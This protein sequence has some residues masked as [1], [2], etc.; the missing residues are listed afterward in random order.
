MKRFFQLISCVA[1]VALSTSSFAQTDETKKDKA[2]ELVAKI[3]RTCELTPEQSG[4]LKSLA[5]NYFA[6]LDALAQDKS[7]YKEKKAALDRNYDTKLKEIMTA[8]QYA[9]MQEMREEQ[10]TKTERK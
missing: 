1:F 9:K 8:E 5:V 2:T 4:T 10:K 3:T 7:T 6:E